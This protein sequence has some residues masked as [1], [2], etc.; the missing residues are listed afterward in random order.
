M[1]HGTS[2]DMP[3]LWLE[4]PS[5]PPFMLPAD[6]ES[7]ARL[8]RKIATSGRGEH[9]INLESQSGIQPFCFNRTNSRAAVAETL[10]MLL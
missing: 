9:A 4:L 10:P 6:R 2:R 3:N 5:E 7:L 8:S 1:A